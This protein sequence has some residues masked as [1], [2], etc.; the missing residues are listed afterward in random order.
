MIVAMIR[1]TRNGRGG[2]T[3]TEVLIAMVIFGIIFAA[4]TQMLLMWAKATARAAYRV[5]LTQVQTDLRSLQQKYLVSHSQSEINYYPS[6]APWPQQIP[7]RNPVPWSRPAPGFEELGWA[8]SVSP[9]Y[10]QYRIDGWATGYMVSGIGDLD[11][12]GGLELYRIWG[13]VGMFEGPLP[14]EPQGS[15]VNP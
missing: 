7:C 3:L 10:L 1:R 4:F 11:R 14:V 5:R 15:P 9:T 6:V 2:F 13:D 12:D 8:P